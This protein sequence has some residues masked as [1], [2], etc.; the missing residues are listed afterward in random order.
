MLVKGSRFIG[1]HEMLIGGVVK[2]VTA[3]TG[4]YVNVIINNSLWPTWDTKYPKLD[5]LEKISE[6]VTFNEMKGEKKGE[7]SLS[8][9]SPASSTQ[10][11]N[12]QLCMRPRWYH[13]F[14]LH[15]MT[16]CQASFIALGSLLESQH[17]AQGRG[18][19]ACSY[20]SD[21]WEGVIGGDADSP[22]WT[23]DCQHSWP[24]HSKSLGKHF[25]F[26]V[27]LKNNIQLNK[28]TVSDRSTEQLLW[29]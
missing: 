4:N 1:T 9:R 17:L 18:L 15:K 12:S 22:S 24:G 21:D 20:A 25:D 19:P 10:V 29:N 5:K 28:M 8:G 16:F 13:D 6:F 11:F 27:A 23:A 3:L 7:E 2:L 14:L 26:N